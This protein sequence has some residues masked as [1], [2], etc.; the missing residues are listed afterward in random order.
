M[1]TYLRKEFSAG[2]PLNHY[3]DNALK[4]AV[5]GTAFVSFHKLEDQYTIVKIEEVFSNNEKAECR[6]LYVTL[7]LKKITETEV[8]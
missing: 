8:N 7:V 5:Y 6:T 2:M 3:S 4:L 1:E